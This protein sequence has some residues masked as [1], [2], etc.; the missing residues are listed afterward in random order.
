MSSG[1][2]PIPALPQV[3]S[4]VLTNRAFA[5]ARRV[6]LQAIHPDIDQMQHIIRVADADDKY[7]PWVTI[8]RGEWEKNLSELPGNTPYYPA[9]EL[10]IA[11]RAPQ[12]LTARDVGR[13]TVGRYMVELTLK[14]KEWE[15]LGKN[16]TRALGMLGSLF[17]LG[18]ERSKRE[19]RI[20]ESPITGTAEDALKSAADSFAWITRNVHPALDTPENRRIVAAAQFHPYRIEI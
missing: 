20:H 8:F 11:E 6:G 18:I 10:S 17:A 2:E 13:H 9:S 3:P 12:H 1:R 4:V 16:T 7:V 15:M 14:R 5:E 19:R